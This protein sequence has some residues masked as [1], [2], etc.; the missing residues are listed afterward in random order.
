M[1]RRANPDFRRLGVVSALIAALPGSLLAQERPTAVL[2]PP[3]LFDSAPPA[4]A[5]GAEIITAPR[6]TPSVN[7]PTPAPAAAAPAPVRPAEPATTAAPVRSPEPA[8]TT[9][10]VR[11]PEP[12]MTTAPVRSP[13]PAMTTGA[14]APDSAA[15][16][17]PW[18]RRMWGTM[19]GWFGR[20]PPPPPPA[21][22]TMVAVAPSTTSTPVSLS[23]PR[24]STTV[25]PSAGYAQDTPDRTIRTGVLGECVKTGMWE[26]SDVMTGCGAG[27]TVAK[28]EERAP[29]T[30]AIEPRMEPVEVQP[31]AAP[32]LKE[33]KSLDM[34]PVAAEPAP[35]PEPEPI[36][37]PE[38]PAPEPEMTTLS[39][40][41]LFA[42]GSHQLKP[43]A[44]ASL[45]EFAA[46]LKDM[47]YEVIKIT[48]HTDP[49]GK[50]AMNDKLSRQRAES[51]KRYLV[52]RGI[53]AER[54]ETEGVGS[55]MPM[56]I[57][58]DCAALPRTQKAAC[59]QPDRRVEI[60][61]RGATSRMAA[62]Q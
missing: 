40:D 1:L 35:M 17:E 55:S 58:T 48:G 45:D 27:Q 16:R 32:A 33:E 8:M 38:P 60:E 42:L 20:N 7:A 6:G 59:Y 39:A 4:S 28:V 44:R 2:P 52:S 25:E 19:T 11:S 43:A 53:A 21:D 24:A 46:K 18:Y 37:M 49:T 9:A 14:A 47:D 23:S 34:E 5:Q 54:I 61:V 56:V 13:E 29:M 62:Q 36:A 31:L 57:E 15:A 12:A 50:A 26:P 41:A 22:P 30:A 10:P 51:V 3:S